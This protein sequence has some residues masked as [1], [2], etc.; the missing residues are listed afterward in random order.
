VKYIIGVLVLHFVL[1]GSSL[2]EKIKQLHT[3]EPS[4]RYLLLNSIKRELIKLNRSQREEALKKLK[5][6]KQHKKLKGV[7]QGGAFDIL[8]NVHE[9]KHF[10]KA[11]KNSLNQ[12]KHKPKQNTHK[13]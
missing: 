3:I 7:H 9:K 12:Q 1:Y 11:S 13:K 6:M 4:K 5:K 8:K 10:Q 2:E